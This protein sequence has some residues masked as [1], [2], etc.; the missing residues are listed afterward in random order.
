[1]FLFL[2]LLLLVSLVILIPLGAARFSYRFLKQRIPRQLALLLASLP[3]L[4]VGY[5]IFTAFYPN[6]DFYEE[7][8][9]RITSLPYPEDAEI[10]AKGA[11]Y[12]DQFGDY[13]SCAKIEVELATYAQIKQKLG[14]NPDFTLAAASAVI[15]TSAFDDVAAGIP[16]AAYEACFVRTGHN[17]GAHMFIGFLTDHKTIILYRSSS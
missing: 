6:D 9:T 7:E 4:V 17:R 15:H 11:T 10:V 8:F 16:A 1:M 2:L 13:A 14:A 12:P 3:I 5:F